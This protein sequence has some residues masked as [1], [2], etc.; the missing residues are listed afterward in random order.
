MR[1][2]GSMP[3]RVPVAGSLLR[4][5]R[6]RSGLAEEQIAKD[7]PKADEWEA[8]TWHPT[9]PQ[10]EQFA[11]ATHT[12]VGY[13]FLS[14]PPALPLP[15]PD[16]RTRNYD[17]V[18]EPGPDLLD[19]IYEGQQRQD[20]YRDYVRQIGQEPVQ[21][22]SSVTVKAD[23]TET[24]ARM[25]AAL[26][27]DTGHRGSSWA[28]AFRTLASHAEN[29][30]ILVMTSGIA[31][32][33]THRK[34]DPA[35][36][37]GFSL[38]DAYAPVVF[39]NGADTKAAQIFTLAHE[40]AHIWSGEG[41]VG[42]AAPN[43]RS[44]FA[45]ERWCSRVAAEFLVPAAQLVDVA[46]SDLGPA[47]LDKLAARFRTSTL[48]VLIS[49]RNVA[50]LPPEHF[51]TMYDDELQRVLELAREPRGSQGGNFYH[52]Q[53]VRTSKRFAQAVIA[54]TLEG[55]TLYRDAFR[56]LGFKKQSAFDNLGV[57]P[58]LHD[59]SPLG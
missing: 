26:A 23:V 38:V 24:A 33:N 54:D 19:V 56:M 59:A 4:W 32:S 58:T 6:E 46:V 13:F 21:V 3:T 50:A 14:E 11:H 10:L 39:V 36:F 15:I 20:W 30:G 49:L 22:V 42:D 34:L 40:L 45:V 17:E 55:N 44:R 35:E 25:R 43:L 57:A 41:G 9:L 2:N 51:R 18:R 1:H 12:P 5:A 47:L 7:F 37:G 29:L 53:P 48:V 28:D 31:G 52:T 16:F 27:F 8:E